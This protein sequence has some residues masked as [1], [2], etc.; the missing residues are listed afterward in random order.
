MPLTRT[1]MLGLAV[2]GL[3]G[4]TLAIGPYAAADSSVVVH[5][6]GDWPTTSLQ[7]TTQFSCDHPGEEP[8][9]PLS[10]IF[11]HRGPDP[12]PLGTRTWGLDAVDPQVVNGVYRDVDSVADL[13]PSSLQVYADSDSDG[14]AWLWMRT[15]DDL[16]W[17]GA[18][19]VS[20]AAGGWHTLSQ[21]SATSYS[22]VERHNDGTATGQTFTGTLAEMVAHAGGGTF[23]GEV[24]FGLGCNAAGRFS[25]DDFV[26]G[27]T[28]DVITYDLEGAVTHTRIFGPRQ[29]VVAGRPVTLKGL[30]SIKSSLIFGVPLVLEAKPFGATRWRR[31][32]T[33][34]QTFDGVVH[35]AVRRE[36]PLV[37][38][39]YRYRSLE[40]TGR[41][42]SVSKPFVVRVRAAVSAHAASPAIRR[43]DPVVV[44]GRVRPELR[45]HRVVLRHGE[46]RL[47][48][49]RVRHDGTYAVRAR[50]TTPGVWRLRVTVGRTPGNLAGRSA[51]VRVRVA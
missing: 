47:A 25:I 1:L 36:R 38:T 4:A 50:S 39:A 5:G 40:T 30:M 17:Y 22:W 3:V 34:T 37:R 26:A 9:V 51:V 13:A 35:P 43:G 20:V 16:L 46:D 48:S 10:A 23:P 21:D 12:V 14:V 19:P 27:T 45:G 41:D 42:G 2:V 7:G 8:D 32:G 28:G 44:F 33:A 18:S 49:A 6:P 31:A 15:G 11:L 29:Q 24:G